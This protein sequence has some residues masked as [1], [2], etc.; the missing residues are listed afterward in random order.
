[1]IIL[2]ELNY[3]DYYEDYYNDYFTMGYGNLILKY[4]D[5]RYEEDYYRVIERL[6]LEHWSSSIRRFKLLTFS[7]KKLLSKYTKSNIIKSMIN[8]DLASTMNELK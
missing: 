7:Q 8:E 2:L 6:L 3:N 4:V 1:M 5:S